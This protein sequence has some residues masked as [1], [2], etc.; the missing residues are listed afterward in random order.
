MASA[1]PLSPRRRQA[2]RGPGQGRGARR[3][4]RAVGG[5]VA[6][7]G[8]RRLTPHVMSGRFPGMHCV[9][10]HPA[11]PCAVIRCRSAPSAGWAD[12]LILSC[13]ANTAAAASKAKPTPLIEAGPRA[14]PSGRKEPCNRSVPLHCCCRVRR[15]GLA[16]QAQPFSV[17]RSSAPSGQAA[18]TLAGSPR[19]GLAAARIGFRY[20]V[21]ASH[22]RWNFAGTGDL[23]ATGKGRS[24]GDRHAQGKVVVRDRARAGEIGRYAWLSGHTAPPRP[25]G[26]RGVSRE[27]RKRASAGRR[28]DREALSDAPA[29]RSAVG[30]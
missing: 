18:K 26:W 21:D 20:G 7:Q 15:C 5:Q 9:A 24:N 6:G 25:P 29:V 27:I 16:G 4:C 1:V 11:F 30:S 3:S 17:T 23:H 8:T 22:W 12:E 13:P 14:C 2:G 28:R 10:G 19:G